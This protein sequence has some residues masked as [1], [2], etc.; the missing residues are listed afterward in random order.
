MERGQRCKLQTS[1]QSSFPFSNDLMPS[2]SHFSKPDSSSIIFIQGILIAMGSLEAL[3]LPCTLLRIW[4]KGTSLDTCSVSPS[5][6]SLESHPSHGPGM[7]ITSC[8]W[9]PTYWKTQWRSPWSKQAPL[10]QELGAI[11][12]VSLV[13]RAPACSWVSNKFVVADT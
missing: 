6:R 13:P 10:T 8:G 3:R 9:E 2:L 4:N 1:R 5:A 12:T 11:V 7:S